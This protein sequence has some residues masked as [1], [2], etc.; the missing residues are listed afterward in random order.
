MDS[1]PVRLPRITSIDAF[2][3]LVMFLMIAAAM[4]LYDVAKHENLKDNPVWQTIGFH[5]NHVAWGGGS[6]HDM[7]QP[8]FSFLVGVALPFSIASR[9]AKGQGIGW[10]LF[11][12]VLR[13]L[14]L[15]ALGVFLESTGKKMTNFSFVNTLS[16]IG[17]GYVF[18]FLLGFVRPLWQWVAAGVILVGYWALFAL[19]PLPPEGF[20]LTSV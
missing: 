20:D 3:G 1:R 2:R 4:R 7:I 12:A 16:Q 13:A 8:G 10:M 15:V 17:L 9:R 6:L 14:A 18:L 11:H 19:W 5:T